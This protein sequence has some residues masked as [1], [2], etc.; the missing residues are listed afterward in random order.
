MIH[1]QIREVNVVSLSIRSDKFHD[2]FQIQRKISLYS[3]KSNFQ[4]ISQFTVFGKFLE[5][6]ERK[7][8]QS[9][10]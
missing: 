2:P 6:F 9:S 10:V 5:S 7:I 4:F 1:K 3:N 8:Y